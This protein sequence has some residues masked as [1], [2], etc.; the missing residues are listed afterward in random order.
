M[1]KK[2]PYDDSG[3]VWLMVAVGAITALMLAFL[4]GSAFGIFK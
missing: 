1:G 2:N 3:T 4:F